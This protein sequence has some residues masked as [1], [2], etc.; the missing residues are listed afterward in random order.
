MSKYDLL[1][2]LALLV[3]LVAL[4]L[5]AL[6][7]PARLAVAD[8]ALRQQ[9]LAEGAVT[10]LDNCAECHGPDGSGSGAMP[11]LN[12]TALSDADPDF[13]YNTIARA[14]HGSEMA[15]WHLNEGGSLNDY[16][17]EGLVNLIRFAD[18]A[19][20]AV[21]AEDRQIDQ[22]VL[23][24]TTLINAAA[25]DPHHCA[26]CHEQPDVHIDQF[27]LDCARCHTLEAWVPARLTR[28]TFMLDH[29]SEEQV[30]CQACHT[31][32]YAEHD[33]FACHDEHQA[34]EM[35]EAHA[36]EMNYELEACIA[37]HPTG[38]P[39]EAERLLTSGL[40]LL[41]ETAVSPATTTAP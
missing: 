30:P 31:H 15:A 12:A 28:H 39:G 34:D 25:D 2:I 4:P 23:P 24:E 14:G 8:D 32:T 10:Y 19:Q 17:I 36:A 26:A 29:G 9:Y 20:I 40:S 3:I 35:A 7:E 5:Y 18:W 22:I 6:Q 21:I 33:C 38:E 1:T 11:A 13:L 27:G 16:Q 41:V 37:C